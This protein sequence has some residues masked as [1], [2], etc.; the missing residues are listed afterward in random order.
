MVITSE[1]LNEKKNYISW[2]R[3]VKICV[4][5]LR[6]LA[7]LPRTPP[8]PDKEDSNYADWDTDNL[9]ISGWLLNSIHEKIHHGY[10][11]METAKQIRDSLKKAQL[12][13]IIVGEHISYIKRVRQW[14][15]GE[16]D[17][18]WSPFYPSRKMGG[19]SSLFTFNYGS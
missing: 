16:C 6:N 13:K 19:A 7:H 1:K 4:G 8:L 14:Q 5:S 9:L 18:G 10:P 15:R 12:N 11:F 3:Y 2:A 17:N